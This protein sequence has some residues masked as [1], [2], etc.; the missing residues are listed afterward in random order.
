MLVYYVLKTLGFEP[1]Q[2]IGFIG[3]GGVDYEGE[4]DVHGIALIKLQVQV[5]R[6]TTN[7]IGE[8]DIRSFR[9]ALQN[10]FQGCFI[11]LSKFTQ[12]ALQSANREGYKPI[13]LVDG[14]KFI[15]LFI[16]QYDKIIEEIR[17]DENDD[18]EEKLIFKKTLF[19][20]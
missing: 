5:K 10:D 3:D 4:L 20:S 17:I 12:R 2:K 7:T 16:Q 11:T 18:L 19:P 1:K 13:Q 8:R 15:E 6:Y 14:M 9:G